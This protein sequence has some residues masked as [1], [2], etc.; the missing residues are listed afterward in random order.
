LSFDVGTISALLEGRAH[1]PL[2]EFVEG[3]YHRLFLSALFIVDTLRPSI[4][5]IHTLPS[6][7]DKFMAILPML[8]QNYNKAVLALVDAL[9]SFLSHFAL[10]ASNEQLEEVFSTTRSKQLMDLAQM[11]PEAQSKI[12]QLLEVIALGPGGRRA[13]GWALSA[14]P[15]PPQL[16]MI[17]ARLRYGLN[18]WCKMSALDQQGWLIGSGLMEVLYEL[19]FLSLHTPT[20]LDCCV[21]EILD[22]LSVP[23]S[24]CR[25]LAYTLILRHLQASPRDAH[26][27]FRRYVECL[28]H[29]N[30]E[31]RD[32]AVAH[33]T[34]FHAH[35]QAY[36][37]PMCRALFEIL[38]DVPHLVVPQ[39]MSIVTSLCRQ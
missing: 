1:L 14:L 8:C 26:L 13:T 5:G 25:L 3:R 6:L 35:C 16:P 7:L 30:E 10:V 37:A 34:R 32:E 9:A 36:S 20:L 19:D 21:D 12:N 33:A 28:S 29:P 27:V 31:V 18:E 38:G 24:P 22:L 39:L 17:M 15:S 4:F 11:Y 2:R 23:H